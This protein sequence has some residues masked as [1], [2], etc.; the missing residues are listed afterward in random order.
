MLGDYIDRGPDSKGVLEQLLKLQE[1]CRLIPLLGNHEEMLLSARANV[2]QFSMWLANGGMP[3]LASYGGRGG[4]E[5]VPREH[6]AF[7]ESC[8]PHFETDGFIFMHAGYNPDLALAEQDITTLRWR[9]IAGRAPAPHRSGKIAIVGHT[10]Q[11]DGEI[12][13]LPH[14]KCIDTGCCFGGWLTA[15]DV[16]SGQIWQANQQGDLRAGELPRRGE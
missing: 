11:D 5:L 9:S 12:L 14:I 3:T 8:P 13:D 1:Q 15:L 16:E 4:L 2:A 7:F 10:P 6:M